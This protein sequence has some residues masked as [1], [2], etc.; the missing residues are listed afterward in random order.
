MS[1][2]TVFPWLVREFG[3]GFHVGGTDN[4][5]HVEE[6]FTVRIREGTLVQTADGYRF[7]PED[8]QRVIVA[9]RAAGY[10]WY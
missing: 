1:F 4:S 9:V 5:R 6:W 7:T 3:R 10:G 2:A 8:E